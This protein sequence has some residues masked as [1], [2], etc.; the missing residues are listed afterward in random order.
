MFPLVTSNMLSMCAS[1]VPPGGWGILLD[2]SLR[3]NTQGG[4]TGGI[5]DTG[6]GCVGLLG[7]LFF[8]FWTSKKYYIFGC[9]YTLL[10]HFGDKN[11][12]NQCLVPCGRVPILK[13]PY[14]NRENYDT[15]R[16]SIFGAKNMTPLDLL[17]RRQSHVV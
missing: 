5:S 14:W 10:A 16:R 1:G 11:W 7:A 4:V 9:I 15:K 6:F 13:V 3:F 17:M 2:P 12:T 8:V